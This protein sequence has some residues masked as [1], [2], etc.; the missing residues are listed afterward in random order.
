MYLG[1]CNKIIKE[2]E[3][4]KSVSY[5]MQVTHDIY[6]QYVLRGPIVPTHCI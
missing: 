5:G 4:D 3:S 1:Y 2:N 6:V